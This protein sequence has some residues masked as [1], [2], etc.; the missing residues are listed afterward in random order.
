MPPYPV[1]S[2]TGQSTTNTTT[3]PQIVSPV[4]F[5]N[6]GRVPP[7]VRP[8]PRTAPLTVADR[9]PFSGVRVLPPINQTR[10]PP[11]ED[12]NYVTFTSTPSHF[13]STPQATDHYTTI[14]STPQPSSSVPQVRGYSLPD[15]RSSVPQVRGYSL[16]DIRESL[17]HDEKENLL[18]I[19]T[20]GFPA[21]RVARAL[22]ECGG[23][24][25]KVSAGNVMYSICQ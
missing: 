7:P 16:P 22:K 5:S 19:S 15:I 23:D 25:Q 4:L 8:K 13:S 3:Y 24:K 14:S 12:D 1:V 20:M 11:Y 17:T 10:P 2:T 18:S 9:S 21:P 6:P